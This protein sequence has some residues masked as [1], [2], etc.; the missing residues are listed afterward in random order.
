MLWQQVRLPVI[1]FVWLRQCVRARF[2]CVRLASPSLSVL[3]FSLRYLALSVYFL[4]SVANHV[5]SVYSMYNGCRS[6]TLS[7]VLDHRVV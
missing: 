2:I 1:D 6:E 5:S 4:L 7:P 3:L